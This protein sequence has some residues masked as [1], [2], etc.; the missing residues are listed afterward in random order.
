MA[1]MNFTKKSTQ[2]AFAA[3]ALVAASPLALAE[4]PG[5]G[6]LPAGS[7]EVPAPRVSLDGVWESPLQKMALAEVK[8]GG[9]IGR[10]VQSDPCGLSVG[11]EVLRGHLDENGVFSGEIRVCTDPVCPDASPRWLYFLALASED[12]SSLQG[13]VAPTAYLGC[14]KLFRGFQLDAAKAAPLSSVVLP[15]P[16]VPIPGEAQVVSNPKACAIV[17]PMGYLQLLGVSEGMDVLEVDG[18]DW[19]SQPYLRAISAGV[20]QVAI[21]MDGLPETWIQICVPGGK[22]PVHLDVSEAFKLSQKRGTT[23]D[24]AAAKS[25]AKAR[26]DDSKKEKEKEEEGA[27]PRN[28]RK[29]VIV[30]AVNSSPSVA[31]TE[32]YVDGARYGSGGIRADGQTKLKLTVGPHVIRASSRHG[33]GGAVDTFRNVCVRADSSDNKVVF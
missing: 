6:T 15:P 21:R 13:A 29:T 4:G 2:A 31:I 24:G 32:L 19:H 9:Y 11:D 30:K 22:T 10:L 26:R 23:K 8:A 33:A 20:H 17:S 16:G 27:C 3:V 5:F 12:G 18:A 7:E 14:D 1:T 28:S 25:K